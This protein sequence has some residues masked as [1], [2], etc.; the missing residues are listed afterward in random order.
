MDIRVAISTENAQKV[1]RAFNRVGMNSPDLT[2]AIFETPEQII[3]IGLPPVR[4]EVLTSIDGVSF[5]ECYEHN[6]AVQIDDLIVP[7]IS[8]EDLKKNKKASGRYKDLD[9]LEHL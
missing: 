5:E 2:P 1:T 9:D 3:R 7:V 8:L 6:V 4:I